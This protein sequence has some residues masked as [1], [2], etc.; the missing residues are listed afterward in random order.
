[1]LSNYFLNKLE[2]INST[3]NKLKNIIVSYDA[4]DFAIIFI[5]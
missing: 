4:V 5:S 2:S 3:Y 1:M